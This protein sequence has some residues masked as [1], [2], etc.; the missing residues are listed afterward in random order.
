LSGNEADPSNLKNLRA[1]VFDCRVG[2]ATVGFAPLDL[3]ARDELRTTIAIA[4]KRRQSN[5]RRD[6]VA[7]LRFVLKLMGSEAEVRRR[8]VMSLVSFKGNCGPIVRAERYRGE[9][10]GVNDVP[11]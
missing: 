2:E 1:A 7:N 10:L 6:L 9:N 5:A 11:L 3:L 4:S 8:F